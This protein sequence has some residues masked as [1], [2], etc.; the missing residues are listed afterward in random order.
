MEADSILFFLCRRRYRLNGGFGAVFRLNAFGFA[1]PSPFLS[2]NISL[3]LAPSL[4]DTVSVSVPTE[5]RL[6]SELSSP[7]CSRL[8][9]PY[10]LISDYLPLL[11]ALS[12]SKTVSLSLPTEWRL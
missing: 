11:L 5:W 6:R 3:M 7:E 10:P 2:V 4:P 12:F 8:H 1:A 9:C